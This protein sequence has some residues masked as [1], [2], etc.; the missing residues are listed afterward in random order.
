MD[1]QANQGNEVPTGA[2]LE[3][4]RRRVRYSPEAAASALGLT[5]RALGEYE[6]GLRTPSDDLIDAMS[7]LY[8]V[9]PGRFA[10]RP[11]VPRVP[12]RYD[13][14]TGTLWVAWNAVQVKGMDNERLCRSIADAIRTTRSLSNTSPIHF[15]TSELPEL[16]KL[17]DLHDDALPDLFMEFLRLSPSEALLLVSEMVVVNS[18]HA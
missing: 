8:G 14:D 18:V 11:W 13:P 10:S 4:A 7:T 17:F 5:V 1:G 16:A 12:S 2:A 15:R 6:S 9:E 3:K